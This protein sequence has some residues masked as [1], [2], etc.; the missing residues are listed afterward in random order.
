MKKMY[1]FRPALA[2]SI[3]LLIAMPSAIFAADGKKHFKQ[4]LKYEVN[5]QWDKAAQEYALANAEA[6]S[7]V[8]Y[9]L[10]LQRAL[11]SAGIMLAERGDMLAQQK[12]YNAAYAA[13]RQAAAFDP[14]NEV[15]KFK[16]RRMLEAQGLASPDSG[17]DGSSKPNKI[18]TSYKPG[19]APGDQLATGMVP[20]ALANEVANKYVASHY[21]SRD[22]IFRGGTLKAA[23]ENLAS[24]MKLNVVFDNNTEQML[25]RPTSFSVELKDVTPAKALEIILTTN[26]LMYAPIDSRTIVIASDNQQTRMKYEMQA[27]RVFYVKTGDINEM[28]NALQPLG[29]KQIVPYKQLNA[30][31]VR[32]T[33]ANLEVAE[34][35]LKSLDKDKAEVLIDINMYQVSHNNLLSLGNQFALGDPTK[36]NTL[37][38]QSGLGGVAA[39]SFIPALAARTLAGPFGI[40]LGLPSSSL[41]AFQSTG[42]AKL[43]ASTQVHVLDGE[44]HTIRLGQRVPIQTASYP[45]VG[46]PASPTGTT[47]PNTPG[48]IGSATNP[49]SSLLS[50]SAFGFGI[51]QIQYENVGLNIDMTPIVTSDEVQMK[52]KIDSTSIDGSTST[53]TPTFNQ[54]TMQAVAKIRDGQTTMIAGI[55]Q[56][57]QSK[58]VKGLPLIGLIPILGRFFT[59]PDNQNNQSDVV[60]TVTPHILRSAEV[61]GEDHLTMDIG[62][63]QNPRRQLT[64]EQ[65]LYRADRELAQQNPVAAGKESPDPLTL[66][67]PAKAVGIVS[68]P[69]QPSPGVF[70]APDGSGVAVM[71]VPTEVHSTGAAAEPAKSSTNKPAVPVKTVKTSAQS[72]KPVDDDDD[73]DDD[74]AANKPNGP[75]QVIIRASPVA[76]KGQQLAAAVIINGD[77]VV[78]GANVALTYDP[79]VF[80]VKG[81]RNGGM[82]NAGGVDVEPQF[83]ADSGVL[84]VTLQRPDGAAGIPAR[85]Q[86]LYVILEVKGKGKTTLGLG[87]LTSFRTAS[88]SPVPVSL[89]GAVVDV[90]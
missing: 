16:M 34:H 6:P 67:P 44:Q 24:T 40:A 58:N 55:S 71:P 43:L 51:P 72:S 87:E 74:T 28:R 19:A 84:N 7:N 29:I 80:D 45:F 73:D 5:K 64:I 52:M 20:D 12:D 2:L 50:S 86:L 36:P 82:L 62:P 21:R 26:G 59:T 54:T 39:Q 4:G 30:F 60:I 83:S 78:T 63:E 42:N 89:Q 32:D 35:V 61:T 22:V 38:L 9:I 14:T 18:E 41:T 57:T 76:T 53:L 75:V 23:I 46:N 17:G 90:K 68:P 88:G 49:T 8:E 13:Y 69:Y 37:G 15:A 66:S 85:G 79:N 3:V 48:A 81:V 56:N 65:I 31:V 10:H 25:Q 70:V 77:A 1:R 27:V 33:P 11:V 47:V